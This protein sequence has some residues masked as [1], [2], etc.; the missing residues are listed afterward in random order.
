MTFSAGPT[1]LL[2]SLRF[3]SQIEKNPAAMRRHYPRLTILSR[4]RKDIISC[5][6]VSALPT[7]VGLPKA[8]KLFLNSYFQQANTSLPLA[9]SP[10]PPFVR[11]RSLTAHPTT[12]KTLQLRYPF[13]L[14]ATGNTFHGNPPALRTSH[15]PTLSGAKIISTYLDVLMCI[16]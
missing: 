13:S 4:D 15:F 14:E 3:Q 8:V 6:T 2:S 5:R 9:H 12:N 10:L 7:P 11:L 16:S 1:I